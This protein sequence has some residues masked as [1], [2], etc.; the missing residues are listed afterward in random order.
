M[1]NPLTLFQWPGKVGS[2]DTPYIISRKPIFDVLCSHDPPGLEPGEKAADG[3]R[4]QVWVRGVVA[5]DL[6]AAI[7]K[8]VIFLMRTKKVRNIIVKEIRGHEGGET[9]WPDT[10]LT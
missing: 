2:V 9:K 3:L 5:D 1:L 10:Q 4:V 7:K 6:D 8:V